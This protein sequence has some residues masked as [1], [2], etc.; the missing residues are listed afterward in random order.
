METKGNRCASEASFAL[1][2]RT[3]L[4][5]LSMKDGLAAAEKEEIR[6]ALQELPED[7]DDQL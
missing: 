1:A 2:Y 5:S 6:Q 3:A 7:A 4:R